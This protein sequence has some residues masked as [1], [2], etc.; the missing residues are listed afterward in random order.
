[1][2]LYPAIG[3][4]IRQ[5]ALPAY[6]ADIQVEPTEFPN[7]GTM[8]GAALVKNAMYNGELLVKLLQG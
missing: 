5:Q 7:L 6:S 1:A 3:A 4:S 8:P 2:V